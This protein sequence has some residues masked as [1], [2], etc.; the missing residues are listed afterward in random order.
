[1]KVLETM[2]LTTLHFPEARPFLFTQCAVPH[3]SDSTANFSEQ[4]ELQ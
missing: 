1:M 4:E 2:R 3:Q